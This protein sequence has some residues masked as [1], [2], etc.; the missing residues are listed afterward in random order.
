[1]KRGYLFSKVSD[2]DNGDLKEALTSEGKK[3]SYLPVILAYTFYAIT[4]TIVIPALPGLTLKLCNDNSTHSSY[5]YGMANFARYISEFFAAPLLGTGTDIIGRKPMLLGSFIICGVEYALLAFFPSIPMLFATRIMAGLFD[6]SN[7][8]V[9]TIITDLA[10]YN[11]DNVTTKFGLITALL[12]IGFVV[13]PLLGGV[14]CDIS[15]SLCF[16]IATVITGVGAVV[17]LFFLDETLPLVTMDRRRTASMFVSVAPSSASSEAMEAS[18]PLL[19]SDTMDTTPPPTTA[20]IPAHRPP[21]TFSSTFAGPSTTLSLPRNDTT[22][23]ALTSHSAH[24]NAHDERLPSSSSQV[25]EPAP[26]TVKRFQDV[27]MTE[28]N[29]IPAL[30]TH[31]KNPIMRDLTIPLF[32][33]SLNVGTGSIWVIYQV[34][35]YHSSSTEVGIYMAFY[36]VVSAFILGVLIKRMI[37]AYWNEEQAS[38]YG[39]LLQAM[40]YL[41]YGLVPTYWSLFVVVA[42]FTVGMVYDPALK[43]L[44]VK[45][46]LLLP[47]GATVQGNLQGV[48]CSIRTLATAFGSLLFAALFAESL[49]MHPEA[50]YLSFVLASF[51][52][53][54]SAVYLVGIFYGSCGQGSRKTAA[55]GGGGGAGDEGA[56][57]GDTNEDDDDSDALLRVPSKTDGSMTSG[58]D[59]RTSESGWKAFLGGGGGSSRHSR[60]ASR[61]SAAGSTSQHLHHH[62]PHHPHAASMIPPPPASLAQT[63]PVAATAA[64]GNNHHHHH[65]NTAMT[66]DDAVPTAAGDVHDHPHPYHHQESPLIS[67]LDLLTAPEAVIFQEHVDAYPHQPPTT[68]ATRSIS[69]ALT[70]SHDAATTTA[71]STSAVLLSSGL[72]GGYPAPVLVGLSQPTA[73]SRSHSRSNSRTVSRA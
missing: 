68:A 50:S 52:Y 69:V 47:D 8:T 28:L 39:L 62:H 7:P 49:K 24:S 3:R 38:V 35:K 4:Y 42:V 26:R 10:F 30:I 56:G 51:L 19:V 48:L 44:I 73:D 59:F 1:M 11:G 53:F 46:S 70:G 25:L 5:I 43:A 2:D 31:M 21:S 61:S 37:P 65:Q 57:E 22:I 58:T 6:C 33:S 20:T 17:T 12:G 23:S 41:G 71:T 67:A 29:P 60:H 40:Q 66:S 64:T 45:E 14:L 32:V 55:N 9:Y 63:T 18:P 13:G 34:H 36:G 27:T 15:I 16:L 54:I 72:L